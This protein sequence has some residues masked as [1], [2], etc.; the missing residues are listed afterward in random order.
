M[1]PISCNHQTS[2]SCRPEIEKM[3]SNVPAKIRKKLKTAANARERVAGM[4]KRDDP[5]SDE[6]DR[7]DGVEQLPPAGREEDARDLE[8]AR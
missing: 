2:I 3:M 7:Q 6:S 4:D 5:G 1:P 8:Y